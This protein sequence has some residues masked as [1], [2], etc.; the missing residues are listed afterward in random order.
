MPKCQRHDRDLRYCGIC[1]PKRYWPKGRKPC[2]CGKLILK[3]LYICQQCREW[4]DQ[5]WR[6]D[7]H[8]ER[9]TRHAVI[10][11]VNPA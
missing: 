8:Q 10:R 2:R 11:Q 6:S 3:E 7:G 5:D 4:D 1:L 9:K